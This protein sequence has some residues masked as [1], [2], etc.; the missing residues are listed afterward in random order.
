MPDKIAKVFPPLKRIAFFK[1]SDSSEISDVDRK[2]SLSMTNAMGPSQNSQNSPLLDGEAKGRRSKSSMGSSVGVNS[3]VREITETWTLIVMKMKWSLLALGLNVLLILFLTKLQGGLFVSIDMSIVENYG[4]VVVELVLLICNI[5]SIWSLEEAASC[6]FGFLLCQKNGFS[7]AVCG[8]LQVSSFGKLGFSQTLSLTSPSRK[9]LSRI[10]IIWI[11]IESLKLLTPFSAIS[12]KWIAAGAFNDVSDCAY[13]IQDP[14]IGPVDRN[15]PNLDTEAGVGEYV[16]GSS[17][18][19]VRSEISDV[20]FT[21][22]QYP[23]ALISAVN[24]GDTVLGPG[25]TV[26]IYTTCSCA[27]GVDP[28]S[29]IDAGVDPSQG[30]ATA[31]NF[32]KLNQKMGLT[33]GMVNSSQEITISNVLSGVDLCGGNGNN[34]LYPLV[35]STVLNNHQS[36]TLEI[37]FMTDGTTA[38][39]APNTVSLV[40]STGQ[41]DIETWLSFGMQ[42]IIE[43]PT[44]LY[45]TPPTVPGSL[46]TLLWWT[47]PNLI[48]I[49]RALVAAGIET[50]YA[51]LFKAAVQRTYTPMATQC[52]RKNTLT[53]HQTVIGMG[54]EGYYVTMVMLA[55]QWTI[56]I[57]SVGA[58]VLWFFTLHPIGPAVRA[59]QESVY[60]MTLLTSSPHL[61]IGLNDLCNAETYAIWHKLDVVCRIGESL[62]TLENDIGK[63]VVDRPQ[64]VRGIQN[65]KK[66]F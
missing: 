7:L 5:I 59:T 53:S 4:G 42:A 13:F 1:N 39:I 6:V 26:D 55:I 15:W 51:I 3:T 46:T 29:L 11:T 9:I 18:G 37:Q 43:G 21:T 44:S 66:Y 62:D 16:F 54:R 17:L 33:F 28:E 38:S 56:S 22:A 47:S 23:P 32:F 35:C 50:M 58:F 25:F 61:G 40:E 64:M 49:D 60:L 14:K 20:N 57:C 41:A 2:N 63:I 12:L 8:Y 24:N 36:A 19:V 34:T 48:S 30:T 31:S 27:N 52:L 45:F 65:G 10:S